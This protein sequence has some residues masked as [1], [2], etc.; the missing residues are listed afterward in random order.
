MN[1]I[2][3]FLIVLAELGA[4]CVSMIGSFEPKLP[5]SLK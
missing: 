2:A 1:L 4:G 5:S 3:E